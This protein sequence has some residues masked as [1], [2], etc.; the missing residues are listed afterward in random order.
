VTPAPSQLLEPIRL[1]GHVAPSRVL[2]GPHETN[3]GRDRAIGDRH[4]AYYARR[5]AGGAGI[6][7]TETASVHPSDWPYERAPLATDCE[8][9]WSRVAQA[10]RPHGALVLAGLGHTGAQGS[11]AYSQLA[12]WAPSRVPDTASR[13]LPM[14][15]EAAELD[16]LVDGFVAAAGLAVRAGL[17]GVELDAGPSALLRQFHSGLTNQR[18]DSYGSDRLTLTREVLRRVRAE[19][20]EEPVI[21]LRLS[22]D[23]LAPW[24]GVTPEHA[25]EQ[26]V[27]LAELVDLLVVTRG[28]PYSASAYRPDGHTAPGFNLELSRSIRAALVAA[29]SRTAVALQG[30]V[31]DPDGA[32][33]AISG[34]AAD[35]VEMTRALIADA[36]LV[37]KVRAGTPERV[38]PCVLCNQTCR[39]RDNRNPVVTCIADP[40]SGFETKDA[41][42]EAAASGPRGGRRREVLVVGAGPAGLEAA[43]ILAG[44][45]D[46]VLV[47]ERGDRAGGAARL[48]A[49]LPGRA[50]F[51]LLLDWWQA[52]CLRLG[53]RFAFGAEQTTAA[54]AAARRD[55]AGILL[56]T[57]SVPGPRAYP[58]AQ[59]AVV[60][61]DAQV[62][63]SGADG[64]PAGAVLVLD[65]VGGPI[66]LGLAESLAA[67]G[68]QVT[69]VT[70][71]QIVGTM[72][73]MS[74]DLADGNTR[75]LQAGVTRRTSSLL[76]AVGPGTAVLEDR[77]SG[78]Q[79][80][81][82]CGVLVHCGHRLPDEELYLARPGTPRAG[83]C[84]APRSVLE[85]VLEGRRSALDLAVS[86][87]SAV[88][89]RE[90]DVREP[91]EVAAGP[92]AGAR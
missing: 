39:V 16:A 59:G 77:F 37:S 8:A 31:V 46:S 18:S 40:R 90:V 19:L 44:R 54:L 62:L 43:R 63:A 30:S 58:V 87:G 81:V 82:D 41:D 17:D 78:E 12:L 15:M 84:V 70:A 68:R 25:A 4:V 32:T 26:A 79:E 86:G 57:G 50:R 67:A 33:Q 92:L 9:G 60:L 56:A 48:V 73:A 51:D 29:G 35:L 55:G 76:R 45:G 61:T 75:L 49:R 20:G 72:V 7:V 3:L 64:V 13:E 36:D 74:G 24:A 14:E 2:F 34:G 11:S 1:A 52:E 23:E 89:T 42:L 80:Q 85:A 10:C 21:A 53:V 38:R 71:D 91:A 83:D 65:L 6:V 69:V 28:G 88:P 22:C 27:E 66:A 47:A 5:A